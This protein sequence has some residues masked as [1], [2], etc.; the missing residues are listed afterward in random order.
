MRDPKSGCVPHA[1]HEHTQC[2]AG[3]AL[4]EGKAS[5]YRFLQPI[6]EG[7]EVTI[8]YT[9][10]LQPTHLRQAALEERFCFACA[11][12]RCQEGGTAGVSSDATPHTHRVAAHK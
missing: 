5:C 9:D 3:I 11:C 1:Q 8:C 10:V 2:A 6:A 7:E 4:Y 12:P